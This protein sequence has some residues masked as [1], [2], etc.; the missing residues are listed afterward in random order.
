MFVQ[1]DPD[2]SSTSASL[3]IALWELLTYCFISYLFQN[4]L[5]GHTRGIGPSSS[6]PEME[7]RHTSPQS[8][9]R[10]RL[11]PGM[12][13]LRAYATDMAY[14]PEPTSDDTI[15]KIRTRLYRALHIMASAV[16]PARPCRVEMLH[17]NVDWHRI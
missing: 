7:P 13:H 4:A 11:P 10:R 14:V 8:P 5:T 6:A 9:Q 3:Q 17:R 16:T 2:T 12:V 15:K 1:S